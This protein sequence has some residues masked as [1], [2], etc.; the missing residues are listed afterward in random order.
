PATS[1]VSLVEAHIEK[2]VAI[3][4]LDEYLADAKLRLMV[5]RLRADHPALAKDPLLPHRA[6]ARALG[7]ARSRHIP[8]NFAMD[9]RDR[10]KYFCSEVASA[11]YEAEG[12]TLWMGL[13]TLSSA[14]V[15]SW[16]SEFGVRNSTTQEPSD[17]EYDPQLRVVAEWR[18]PETL[19]DDHLDNA[20]V[21]VRLEGANRGVKLGHAAWLLPV[22]RVMKAYSWALNGVGGVGPIPEGMSATAALKLQAFRSRHAEMRARLREKADQ[23]KARQGYAAP[24]WELVRMAREIP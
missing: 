8:Y 5:L 1:I 23:F 3:A 11:A 24:Y 6:A 12:V 2:G 10:S 16:L 22:A 17:L 21:E 9:F 20:I 4:T 18:D 13:S 15:C 14:G 7:E 19:Q